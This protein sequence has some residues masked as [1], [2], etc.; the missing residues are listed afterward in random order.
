M[1]LVVNIGGTGVT[2]YQQVNKPSDNPNSIL[3]CIIKIDNGVSHEF[4]YI[5][6]AV[7]FLK[8]TI[9]FLT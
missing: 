9:Y 8:V 1:Y 5:T 6:K 7:E 3:I 4:L 2:S